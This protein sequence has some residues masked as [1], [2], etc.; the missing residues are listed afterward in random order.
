MKR[1]KA[2]Q[3]CLAFMMLILSVFLITGCGSNGQTGHWSPS[4]APTVIAEFPVNN[5]ADVPVETKLIT[6]TFNEAMDPDTITAAG[7]F[8]LS[9]PG[10]T[11]ATTPVATYVE[12]GN[13]AVLTLPL[14]PNLPPDGITCTATI[15][16]AARDI[17][18]NAMAGNFVWTFTTGQDTAGTEIIPG[19]TCSVAGGATIPTVLVSDPTSGNLNAT[20]STSGVANSGKKITAT[21]SL[22]MNPT[23]ITPS[24]FTLAPVSSGLPLVPASVTL[25]ATGL[26][27]TLTT[28]AALLANT[29]YTA[30]ITTAATSAAGTAIACPYQ[31]NFTTITPAAT[32]QATINLGA[33][34]PYGV[35]ASTAITLGGGDLTG[36]RVDG[37]VGIHPGSTCNG[38]TSIQVSGVVESGTA[39]AAA[40]KAALLAA[41]NDAIGRTLN[42]CTLG[43]DSLSTSATACGG[44]N[45]FTYK[46][47]LYRSGTSL[48]IVP[49][50]TIVLDAESNQD[51][52]FIFQ[53]ASTIDTIG[54][55][56]HV[57]LV[58]G[59]QAKNVFWLAESSATI[60][61][62]TSDFAGTILAL[63]SITV[64]TGTTMEGRALARNGAVTVQDGALITVPAP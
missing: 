10:Y 26:V 27:A 20:T 23:T 53:S 37:D 59:A 13:Q 41:Y 19:A 34:Q 2:L 1:F 52:V 17:D 30:I 36:L 7:T 56:T 38:C 6:A 24:T 47:G 28:S 60:G 4:S 44:I 31:W 45:N 18:G 48:T 42:L 35:L 58:N 46:P 32:G 39:N 14:T 64:N 50:A 51:A 29:E 16:T 62:T 25:D 15:T 11:P 57:S 54:G 3:T 33:A 49:G 61:G 9:C 12:A 22:P 8:T 55:A 43:S 21:F 5:A 40:A 63:T